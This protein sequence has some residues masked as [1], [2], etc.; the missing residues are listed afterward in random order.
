MCVHALLSFSVI[1]VLLFFVHKK[2]SSAAAIFP[3]M[4]WAESLVTEADIYSDGKKKLA[5]IET[6]ADQIRTTLIKAFDLR[7]EEEIRNSRLPR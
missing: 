1:A 7:I 6:T 4:D 3:I 2:D 5:S